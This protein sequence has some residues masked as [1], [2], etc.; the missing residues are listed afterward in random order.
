MWQRGKTPLASAYDRAR[1]VVDIG[2]FQICLHR[3]HIRT[4][5]R[6][7]DICAYFWKTVDGE[8]PCHFQTP[9]SKPYLLITDFSIFHAF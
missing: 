2:L 9:G 4:Y 1:E 3:F 7:I 8:C 6:V 5:N